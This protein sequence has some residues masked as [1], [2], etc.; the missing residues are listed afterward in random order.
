MPL[1]VVK[2][3]MLA[4]ILL[5]SII[6]AFYFIQP[7]PEI[8]VRSAPSDYPG[9]FHFVT[10]SDGTELFYR[11]RFIH[12]SLPTLL[13]LGDGPDR[14]N[15]DLEY[16]LADSIQVNLISPD[17]RNMGKSER[18]K[19]PGSFVYYRMVD[20]I[21]EILAYERISNVTI[22]THGFGSLIAQSL[23]RRDSL[24][25]IQH[26]ISINPISDYDGSARRSAAKLAERFK[27][28]VAEGEK[29]LKFEMTGY[30]IDDEVGFFGASKIFALMDIY[31]L[32]VVDS[33]NHP[34]T[35][36]FLGFQQ[37]FYEEW[38]VYTMNIPSLTIGLKYRLF[39]TP[40]QFRYQNQST[41]FTIFRG[42][43]DTMSDSAFFTHLSDS[44]SNVSL[45]VIPKSAY[46]PHI[47]Q[48]DTVIQRIRNLIQ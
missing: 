17:Y 48:P 16:V 24:N 15:F 37:G 28:A 43:F 35:S 22:L 11:K 34:Q 10:S 32:T 4:V 6:P 39:K 8:T 45:S 21:R 7:S 14:V 18:L 36:P 9:S 27:D 3:Y 47:E 40:Q 13:L 41:P 33:N 44:L 2:I 1:R 29:S 30:S 38:E 25:Q 46:Y 31:K 19:W 23:A 42:E 20:D 5:V 12:D 26:I